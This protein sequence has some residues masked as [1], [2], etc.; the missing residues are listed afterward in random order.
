MAF[1]LKECVTC[2]ESKPFP[3]D[4]INCYTTQTMSHKCKSCRKEVS[5]LAR[6]RICGYSATPNTWKNPNGK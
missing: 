2:K 1:E 6:Q 5:R 4:F 3:G